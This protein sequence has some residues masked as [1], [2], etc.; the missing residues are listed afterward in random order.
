MV[1]V[2]IENRAQLIYLLTE[3][4]ELEHEIL[5]CYLFAT[6][7]MKDDTSEGIS[8]EQLDLVRDW[9]RALGE[10]VVQEMIHLSTACNLLT[11]VG[12]APQ[13]RRP[14]LP[15]SP[16][17]YP[18]G[19]ELRL[20]PFSV[21]AVDQF[22]MLERPEALARTEDYRASAVSLD[23]LGDIFS[24]ERNFQTVG[25]LYR[26][27]EDGI[28][29][30]SQKLG[31]A[32]LFVGPPA[33]QTAEQFFSLP[34]L[35]PVH[36]LKSAL[37]AINVIVEQGEGASADVEDSHYRRFLRMREEFGEA[38]K[39]DPSFL[40]GRPVL[41]NPYAMTP[42]DVADVAAV[43][44]VDDPT[45]VDLCNVFDGCYELMVQVLGRLFVHAEE[46]DSQLTVLADIAVSLMIEVIQ[47]LGNAITELPAGPSHPGLRAGPSFRLSRGATVPAHAE[48]ARRVFYE[49]LTELARYCRFLQMRP[50]A[51]RI[52][53]STR[54]AL[55][56]YALALI[57]A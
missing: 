38:L 30:L 23:S 1:P 46:A 49:R 8:A 24:S 32:E 48:A 10:I 44:M 41:T 45:A 37:A 13:L 3:A 39:A 28:T 18:P 20:A 27:I 9:R 42:T 31:E 51:P 40:P 57:P 50:D 11:A 21:D 4:A 19:F 15:T 54:E 43:N 2:R 7:S 56:R 6:F 25:E 17:A 33:A 34:G 47:P 14:N 16:R 36:D 5:C 53:D 12:G 35:I 52:L 55:D 22:V 26:G 29:Y